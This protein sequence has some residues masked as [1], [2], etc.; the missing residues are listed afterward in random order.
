MPRLGVILAGC[1]VYDGSEIHEAVVTLLAIDR[2]KAE[3]VIT[4]PDM[5]L[6]EIDHRT[7]AL[8]GATRSV[9]AEAA[10]IA[11]GVITPL[12]EVRAAD[13]DAVVFPGGY[14]AAKNLSN[15][16]HKGSEADILPE[17]RS[18]ILAMHAAGKP[19]GAM[20]IAP[21]LI[22]LAFKDSGIHPTITIGTDPT[23]AATLETLGAVHAT[24]SAH[25]IVIDI[26]NRIVTTPAYMVATSIAEAAAGIERLVKEIIRMI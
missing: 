20:C 23:T 22:A 8:T 14:G 9:L 10:R 19:I 12:E 16:A 11:R 15:L 4:A 3:A 24:A 25:D 2:Q 26:P 17:I 7:G 1:G 18:L 5:L 6:D 21:A 13:L